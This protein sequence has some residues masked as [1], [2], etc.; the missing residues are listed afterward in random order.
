VS[1]E[2]LL[3]NGESG[4]DIDDETDEWAPHRGHAADRIEK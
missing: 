1:G 4:T 3:L 2:R